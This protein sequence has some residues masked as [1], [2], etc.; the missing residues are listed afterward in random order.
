MSYLSH[1]FPKLLNF[2][3]QSFLDFLLELEIPDSFRNFPGNLV[4]KSDSLC[5][6]LGFFRKSGI[7]RCSFPRNSKIR[8]ISVDSWITGF[9]SHGGTMGSWHCRV[10]FF[11]IC[12]ASHIENAETQLSS[13]S[14]NASEFLL[15]F[16]D[17]CERTLSRLYI[18]VLW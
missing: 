3:S 14:Y 5:E 17:E 16:L 7:F 12:P 18:Q 13:T 15:R 11:F 9:L 4:L 1:F 10:F 8:K 2:P 6:I